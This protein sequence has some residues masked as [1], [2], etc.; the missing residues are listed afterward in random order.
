MLKNMFKAAAMLAGIVLATSCGS[1]KADAQAE[2]NPN[3]SILIVYY[4]QTGNTRQLADAINRHL[5]VKTIEI[6]AVDPY[7]GDYDATIERWKNERDSNITV[8]IKPLDVNFDDYTTIF[9]GFPIWGGTYALP[10]K[11]FLEQNDLSGKKIVTFATFGSGGLDGATED[12]AAAQP[13]AEVYR[14]YGVREARIHNAFEELDRYLIENNYK[15]GILETLGDY[16][17]PTICNQEAVEI[18]NAA[19]TGYKFPL[20]TPV[21]VS[22]RE[23]T[24][25][26]DYKYEVES[27]H[28]DGSKGASTIYVTKSKAE[29]AT[30]EFTEV[31][32]H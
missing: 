23:T 7:S 6:E 3:D 10:V 9:L 19:C 2:G 15:E 26:T 27:E 1:K 25:G 29:G 24:K 12:V 14:G 11:T 8:A 16:S 20:G 22:S 21:K 17:E 31:V 28:P 32:R 4:S 18:F 30:P 13:G 5:D